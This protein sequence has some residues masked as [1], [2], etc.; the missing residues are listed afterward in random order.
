MNIEFYKNEW[1]IDS[2][3]D[4][5]ELG[6]E[7]LKVPKLHHKY[8]SYLIDESLHLL[9]KEEDL[10]KLRLKKFDF[11]V[12]GHNEETHKLGWQLPSMGK[13]LKSDA[14]R[15]V[16]ADDDVSTLRLKIRYI[17]E[18]VKYLQDIINTIKYRNNSIN[19]AIEWQKF[20]MG[21]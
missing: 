19:S 2:D 16:D 1:N 5:T 9:K 4:K 6:D 15:Y 7:A 3:I 11:F 12:Q 17:Q 8:Y 20:T 18:V 14:E 13:I 10:R 21:G